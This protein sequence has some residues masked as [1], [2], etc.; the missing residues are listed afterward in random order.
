MSEI[1]RHL[2]ER[3]S[4]FTS[5]VGE[6]MDDWESAIDHN[7]EGVASQEAFKTIRNMHREWPGNSLSLPAILCI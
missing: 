4:C 6:I 1:I 3:P 2:F 7:V 5:T